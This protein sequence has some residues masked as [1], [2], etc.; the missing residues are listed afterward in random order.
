MTMRSDAFNERRMRCIALTLLTVFPITTGVAAKA[1]V[2]EAASP[3]TGAKT[4]P[5]DDVAELFGARAIASPQVLAGLRGGFIGAAGGQRLELSFGIDQALFVNGQLLVTTRI[6]V[7]SITQLSAAQIQSTIVPP[8]P[9]TIVQPTAPTMV[10]PRA[11]DAPV[12][13]APAA[14]VITPPAAPSAPVIAAPAAPVITPV[15]APSAPVITPVAAPSAP[16]IT[17]TAA[18][19]VLGITSG[20]A[21]GAQS[22]AAGAAPSTASTVASTAAAP[23]A[24]VAAPATAQ[25]AAV[26]QAAAPVSAAFTRIQQALQGAPVQVST[27]QSGN[28]TITTIQTSNGVSNVVQIGPGNVFSFTPSQLPSGVMNVIQNSLDNQTIRQ[29]TNVQL[30]ANSLAVMRALNFG[31]ALQR[32]ILSSVR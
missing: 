27:G 31:S 13:V 2:I 9:P 26:Q 22:V 29:T 18:S 16:V 10:V 1:L 14:P 3:A 5:F 15:A 12:I 4:E 17:P 28:T 6:T 8:T 23:P 21:F 20:T 7:P 30:S 24:V 11:P 19:T 25:T 32:Q